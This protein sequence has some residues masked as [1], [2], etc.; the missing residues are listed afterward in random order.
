MLNSPVPTKNGVQLDSFNDTLRESP[1]W[2]KF[3]T[4]LGYDLS[5]PAPI[6]LSDDQRKALA[7][8]LRAA[9][10][11]ITGP[12][13]ID[14]AGNINQNQS[15]MKKM[16]IAAAIGGLA[17]TGL[18]AAGIGPMAGMMGAGGAATGGLTSA[19]PASGLT[20]AG[21]IASTTNPFVVSS[22]LGGA[23][24]LTGAM[25]SAGVSAGL[26]GALT[27]GGSLISGLVEKG[28]PFSQKI[29]DAG[30][31]FESM[32]GGERA[33]RMDR[34]RLMQNYDSLN[35]QAQNARNTNE[36]DALK[37]MSQTS[38][39]MGGGSK[40]APP[41]L[42]Y[43]GQSVQIPDWGLTPPKPSEAQVSGAKTLQDQLAARLAPGGSV[44]PTDPSTYANPGT[45]EN[46]GKW[47]GIAT[48]ALGAAKDWAPDLMKWFK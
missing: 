38:Y 2:Q 34:G 43:N 28:I 18:G 26:G 42:N 11:P 31:L 21:T 35:L 48:G 24:P 41:T 10:V 36:S 47:G 19:L 40:F 12:M 30:K 3:M 13:E 32:A 22:I 1:I 25:G 17:M 33:N 6:H 27:K 9:G 14:P 37:K 20:S 23:G 4:S 7:D 39:I 16:A 15:P 8:Q 29:A 5:R 44:T 46:V 45:M